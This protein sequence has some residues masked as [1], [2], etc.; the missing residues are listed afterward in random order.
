MNGRIYDPKLGRFLQAD[1]FVQSLTFSQSLNRYSYGFNNPLN[2][3][4]PSGYFFNDYFDFVVSVINAFAS[5]F[6]DQSQ[7]HSTPP[8]PVNPYTDYA[9]VGTHAGAFGRSAVI[10]DRASYANVTAVDATIGATAS[11]QTAWKFSNGGVTNSFRNSS[12][13]DQQTDNV[14][15]LFAD[16]KFFRVF[17]T[18]IRDS[19]R[20][21][22]VFAQA[23]GVA[24]YPD[25][26]GGYNRGRYPGSVPNTSVL[27]GERPRDAFGSEPIEG[28]VAV[29]IGRPKYETNEVILMQEVAFKDLSTK[30]GS[31]VIVKSQKSDIWI[32]SG[33]NA[34]IQFD[35]RK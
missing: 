2:G 26:H 31:P 35:P 17:E 14:L 1:P 15:D 34:P 27:M 21:A 8:T 12:A 4:D 3:T 20:D 9:T 30:L 23:R 13:E 16:K 32:F 18:A 19:V 6:Y 11:E 25:G 28:E 22:A 33:N 7:H 24:I 5:L 29:V 10:Q